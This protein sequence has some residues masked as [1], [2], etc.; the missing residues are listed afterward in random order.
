MPCHGD[1]DSVRK[2]VNSLLDQDLRDIEV[3]VVV[4]GKDQDKAIEECKKID[5]PRF[6]HYFL[7]EG[8]ACKA[9][10][11]G[12]E[13]AT[14][15]YISFLP[16][17]AV[18]Y[19][20]VA[21]TW[22]DLLEKEQADGLYGGYK[23][24]DENAVRTDYNPKTDL[25]INHTDDFV[26]E[27]QPYD[28]YLLE[29]QNY[30]DGSFPIRKEVFDKVLWDA[31]IPSLQ[32]WD[33]WLGIMQ[34]GAKIIF[35]KE[36]FFETAWPHQGGLSDHSAHNWL[37]VTKK[38]KKKHGIKERKIC[39]SSV[40]AIPHGTQLA[41]LIDEDFK[42][43]VNMKEHDYQLVYQLGFY[44]AP[45]EYLQIEMQNLATPAKKVVHWIGTDIWQFAEGMPRQGQKQYANYLK[46][47]GVTNWTECEFTRKELAEA[48]IESEVV[49]L[50]SKFFDVTPLPEKFAVAIYMPNGWEEFH[51]LP[52]IKEV[53]RQMPEVTFNLYGG[54]NIP[55]KKAKK[56]L[57]EPDNLVWNGVIKKEDMQ[58]FIS[59]NSALLRL[60]QHD[61][62]PLS[63]VEFFSA[64][65]NVIYNKDIDFGLVAEMSQNSV[66][67]K[68]R[69]AMA[70]PLNTQASEHYRAL[71]DPEKFKAKL[72][73]VM[74]YKPKEYWEDRA[75][76]WNAGEG[77][78]PSGLEDLLK[79]TLKQLKPESVID[80][81][82]GN[83][84][85]AELISQF[86]SDYAGFDISEKLIE[87]AKNKYPDKTFY[88]SRL[89]DAPEDK[90]Y[91][92]AFTYTT[93]QHIK[94]E[95]M[96][97]AIEKLKKIA[98]RGLFIESEGFLTRHYCINHDYEKLFKVL[99]KIPLVKNS[100]G[101]F[102]KN[103][104]YLM[105]VDLCG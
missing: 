38:I 23:F 22:Y 72:Q 1:A 11:F 99:K 9:R 71:H 76:A 97:Q 75:E 35:C 94:E 100:K 43:Y 16:A 2:A 6:T 46:L 30:I 103:N 49:P 27:S 7:E 36:I 79:K 34:T 61:G 64:G 20:G 33:L 14:G 86:T 74:N 62:F 59:R 82:C 85:Y 10:N 104:T 66:I 44:F 13:K 70:L 39:V 73:E 65:R 67:E 95:D 5:D 87:F 105:V 4:N 41:K 58:D 8:N 101:E 96:P 88:A 55:T 89:E 98:K 56:N 42:L 24:V 19:E 69:E 63:V 18:L 90:K 60:P 29:V 25:P 92:L 68:I 102:A 31:D 52:L 57:K 32:D 26:Y 50:P 37:E 21:R 12:A 83:G 80:I 54:T 48:G 53:A 51:S 28:P 93:L 81:G 77:G 3:I 45:K 91:D 17:D 84:R 15:K 40:G 47:M 78:A